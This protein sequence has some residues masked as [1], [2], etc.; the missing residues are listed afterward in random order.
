MG[1]DRSASNKITG[2]KFDQGAEYILE[3]IMKRQRWAAP[4][5]DKISKYIE[6][7]VNREIHKRKYERV[8]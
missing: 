5:R 1:I 2:G 6:R 8:F 4:D 3:R 7:V